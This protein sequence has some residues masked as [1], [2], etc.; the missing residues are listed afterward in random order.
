MRRIGLG[1]FSEL[2]KNFT[3]YTVQQWWKSLKMKKT[4][5][6]IQYSSGGRV[7]RKKTTYVIQQW[8]QS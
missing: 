2:G 1:T 6:F 8:W 3:C 5:H 7:E 4:T